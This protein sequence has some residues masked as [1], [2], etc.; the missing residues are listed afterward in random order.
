MEKCLSAGGKEV[1]IKSVAQAIPTYSMAC[2]KL[3][4]GLCK[5]ID[6][7]V[8]NFWWGS[9]EGKRRTNWVAWEEMTK[10]KYLGGLG[11]KDT[12]LFNL[13]LLVRQAWRILQDPSTLSARIVK[14]V[15]FPNQD[16]LEAE[17]GASPSRVWR[18]IV[19]GR[20]VLKQGIVKKDWLR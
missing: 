20:D 10:P 13:A 14:A 1:L 5:H 19:D 17:I 15:Y 12:E 16:F 11:F 6:G 4:R 7:M 3:P 18:A 9:K 8:R 2:F